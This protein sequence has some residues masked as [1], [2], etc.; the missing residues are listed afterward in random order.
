MITFYS[1]SKIDDSDDFWARVNNIE[2]VL[3]ITLA[4]M[5][6]ENEKYK[7][8][9]ICNLHPKANNSIGLM[10]TSDNIEFIFTEICCDTLKAEINIEI[11]KFKP[12]LKE[13]FTSAPPKQ[14]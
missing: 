9:N 11:E 4:K 6:N 3:S 2:A 13:F 10:Y 7:L 5:L 14:P 1:L 8:V 12:G